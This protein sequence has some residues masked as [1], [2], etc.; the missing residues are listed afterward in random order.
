MVKYS[1]EQE[2]QIVQL[3]RFRKQPVNGRNRTYMAVK[4]IAR[5]INKS[6]THV[7]KMC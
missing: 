2:L 4:D 5:F 7:S 3:F 1:K 6:S